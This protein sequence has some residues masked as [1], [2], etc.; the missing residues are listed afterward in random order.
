M[1]LAAGPPRISHLR[2]SPVKVA[3][4]RSLLIL[5]ISPNTKIP[6][7]VDRESGISLME[8][9]A[10]LIYPADKTGQLVP[11]EGEPRYRVLDG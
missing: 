3:H 11:R 5:T 8:F 9:G 6:A 10:I 4:D 1:V 2:Q 7:I